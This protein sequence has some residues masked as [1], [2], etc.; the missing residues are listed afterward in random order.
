MNQ[1][2]GSFEFSSFCLA[3]HFCIADLLQA[4]PVIEAI[5]LFQRGEFHGLEAEPRPATMNGLGLMKPVDGLNERV[6]VAVSDT[7]D[8]S[9]NPGFKHHPD[10]LGTD[11]RREFVCRLAQKGSI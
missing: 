8:R 6:V 10:R 1:A 4:A 9:L 11:F 7:P 5:Y 2:S 3:G